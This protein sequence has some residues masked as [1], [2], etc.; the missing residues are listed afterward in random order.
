MVRHSEVDEEEAGSNWK[1]LRGQAHEAHS[2]LHLFE[3]SLTSSLG[4][5]PSDGTNIA[6]N[7]EMS[8]FFKDS[9]LPLELGPLT[10]AY[11]EN[12]L[13]GNG[14]VKAV[15]SAFQNG[16]MQQ[17]NSEVNTQN[18][19]PRS[20]SRLDEASEERFYHVFDCLGSK[21]DPSMEV[22]ALPVVSGVGAATT[23]QN[24]SV[25]PAEERNGPFSGN[26]TSI[27]FRVEKINGVAKVNGNHADMSTL[28]KSQ[29]I[30]GSAENSGVPDASSSPNAMVLATRPSAKEEIVESTVSP[31][32]SIP[33]HMSSVK[34]SHKKSNKSELKRS[35]TAR[36]ATEGCK[37]SQ[38][39]DGAAI[40]SRKSNSKAS[41]K[42]AAATAPHVNKEKPRR[43]PSPAR[44]L[45][46]NAKGLRHAGTGAN[47]EAPEEL[48]IHSRFSNITVRSGSD[49]ENFDWGPR[50]LGIFSVS[51]SARSRH[52][53]PD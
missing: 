52:L 39:S 9:E 11:A 33:K 31:G 16:E 38:H 18:L 24:Y 48:S 37:V 26:A 27:H 23:I 40:P 3:N 29:S 21:R 36:Q 35:N 44:P 12:H 28:S 51:A 15:G 49:T 6:D 2:P 17:S 47:G 19:D 41:E 5:G 10:T 32:L 43:A 7:E 22:A 46:A 13:C 45:P 8:N 34:V 25:D 20:A 53:A 4:P 30:P 42:S 1:P 50:S 14:V